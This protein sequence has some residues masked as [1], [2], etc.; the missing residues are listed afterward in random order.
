VIRCPKAD[1]GGFTI[2]EILMVVALMGL[3]AMFAIPKLDFS[4]YRINGAVRGVT[5]LLARAQRLAVT[6]QYDVNVLFDVP[7][8]ALQL[9]DDV[10]NDNIVQSGER[11]LGFPLGEGVAFG[12]GGAPVRLYAPGPVSFTR[13]QNAL[14]EII[15]R[16]DGSAS[17]NGGFYITSTAALMSARPKDG[18]SI[19]VIRSTGRA[20]WYQYNGSTWV[21][22]F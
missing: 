8:N 9:H 3:V 4:A 1:R 20:E 16:R 17:E 22:K 11:V 7:N 2:V 19:E 6:S 13:T 15:F 12:L 14:P 18:R 21:K 10:N 5:A